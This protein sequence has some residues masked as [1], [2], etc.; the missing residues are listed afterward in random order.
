MQ[1]RVFFTTLLLCLSA[2]AALQAKN[3]SIY[4]SAGLPDGIASLHAPVK[5]TSNGIELF[6]KNIFSHHEYSKEVLAHNFSHLIQFLQHG[7]RM[8]QKRTYCKEVVRLFGNKLKSTPFVNPYAFLQLLKELP[9]LLYEYFI[10]FKMADLDPAKLLVNEL[11]LN[12]FAQNVSIFKENPKQFFDDLSTQ[13]IDSLNNRYH[14]TEEITAEELRKSLLLFLEIALS[15]LVWSPYEQTETWQLCKNIADQL[16]VLMETNIIADPDDLNDLYVTLVE[17]YCYF[18]EVTNPDLPVSFFEK[19]KHS[20]ASESH[21]FLEMEEQENSI[22]TKSER[23]MHT[24]LQGEA[25]ARA[26][27]SGIIPRS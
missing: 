18:L 12:H 27:E 1:V 4:R 5:F 2:G 14:L 9:E 24:L 20:V 3:T 11:A 10:I 25:K 22:A 26:R 7:K 15:K 6:L 8:G 23:L 17:R 16:A 19:L 21:L 13:I